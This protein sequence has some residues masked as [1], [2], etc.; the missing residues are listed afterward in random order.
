MILLLIQVISAIIAGF[1]GVME[2]EGIG[3]TIL[4]IVVY[5]SLSTAGYNF[6]S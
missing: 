6:L 2:E 4:K 3:K 5:M 1:V